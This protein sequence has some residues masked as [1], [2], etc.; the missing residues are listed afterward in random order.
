MK[1]TDL[2][3]FL[4]RTPFSESSAVVSYFT[5]EHGF[6]K[7]VFLGA[8]KK[9]AQLFPLNVQ[10]LEF[11]QRNDS[12]LGKLTSAKNALTNMEI[13][14]HPIRSCLAFLIAEIIVK[15]VN[16][17]E[18]D[19]QLYA[20]LEHGVKE[21][22]TTKELQLFPHRFLIGFAEQL[23]FA[24][25]VDHPMP[26]N[27][28]LDDGVFSAD[29]Q[30]QNSISGPPMELLLNIVNGVPIAQSGLQVRREA[31]DALIQYYKLHIDHF[32]QLKS[33][34]ILDTLFQA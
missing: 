20:F 2:G 6:R 8:R 14:F 29:Q 9:N 22:N 11:Y 4:H 13:P 16:H 30:M 25:Q 21:L 5:K 28:Q 15:C 18:K 17:T 1:Q 33:K 24:P 7:L 27:F 19:E 23:G 32:G 12:V 34:D 31:M 3:I 10:E 26:T